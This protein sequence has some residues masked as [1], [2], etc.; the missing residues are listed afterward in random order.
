MYG[1]ELGK[2]TFLKANVL[3]V[4]YC[5]VLTMHSREVLQ[6]ENSNTSS[7]SKYYM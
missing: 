4:S 1:A 2:I 3:I 5:I 7:S 6:G